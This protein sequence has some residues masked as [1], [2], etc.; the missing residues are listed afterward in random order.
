MTSGGATSAS[1]RRI[2]LDAVG[3]VAGDMFVAALLDAFPDLRER[4]L[5]DARAVL[6]AGIGAPVLTEGESGAV[7]ALR[8]GLEAG[9]GAGQ[10]GHGHSHVHAHGHSHDHAH[11][12]HGDITVAADVEKPAKDMPTHAGT[13]PDMRARIDAAALHPGTAEHAGAILAILARAEAGIHRVAIEDVHFHE[14]ADW[15]SLLDVVAAG[16]IA[17]ALDGAEWSIS[18]LPLGGGL[19]RTQHGLLPVPAPAT[20]ALLEGFDWR[21]D[22]VA[23]ERVTPTGAA[24]L[25]HLARP[26]R[27]A[28][29]RLVATG[30]GAGTRAL[31]GMPNVL[32]VLA[33]EEAAPDGYDRD[34]VAVIAFEV[35]DMTGEEIG[36]AAERLRATAGVLDVSLGQLAG[37]KGRPAVSFRLLARPEAAEDAARACFEQTSTIGLRLTEERRLTLARAAGEIAGIAVKRV[38]RPGGA[39]VKA[40]SDALNGATLAERRAAKA[41]A[42][43]RAE[44]AT[45][46]GDA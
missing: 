20:A 39:T 32:R 29:G 36:T 4:V 9:G 18:P 46:G 45:G 37:K 26:G 28:G 10:A 15:D 2:H 38:A 3:G 12:H 19:V 27:P 31:P 21:D 35:D 43:S 14:I 1:V 17:A 23:G 13:Y 44:R 11:H 7:R 25:R 16:S 40:E 24:I 33:F 41:R 22:G 8:F 6:P 34:T 42:E 30:T 5:A